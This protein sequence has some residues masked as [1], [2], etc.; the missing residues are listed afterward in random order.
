MCTSTDVSSLS[1]PAVSSPDDVIGH[2]TKVN[3]KSRVLSALPIQGVIFVEGSKLFFFRSDPAEVE[4][5]PEIISLKEGDNLIL[6]CKVH[7]SP[8]PQ[9]QWIIGISFS[10]QYHSL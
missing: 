1:R 4:P 2:I 10:L 6:E 5:L 8:V 3:C 9:V 7:G